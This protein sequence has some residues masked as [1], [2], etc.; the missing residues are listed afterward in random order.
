MKT[1]ATLQAALN[2]FVEENKK[3]DHKLDV[4]SKILSGDLETLQAQT[5][6][7]EDKKR[8]ANFATEKQSLEEEKKD[9]E[10][11]IRFVKWILDD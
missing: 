2:K 1:E 6:S 5:V 7:F 8:L 11:R 3:I 4:V 9:M 10:F